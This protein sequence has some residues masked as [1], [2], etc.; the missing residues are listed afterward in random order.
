MRFKKSETGS[1]LRLGQIKMRKRSRFCQLIKLLLY[2][3]IKC[4]FS[5][6]TAQEGRRKEKEEKR[7]SM[8]AF[9]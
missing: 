3:D 8:H 4:L 2:S 9:F 6:G 7:G 1:W 5:R